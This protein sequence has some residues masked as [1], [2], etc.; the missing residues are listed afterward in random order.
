MATQLLTISCN[1]WPHWAG[2]TFYLSLTGDYLW[3]A[4]NI[5]NEGFRPLNTI[6]EAA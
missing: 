4:I 6:D 3:S 5:L 2:T 1:M